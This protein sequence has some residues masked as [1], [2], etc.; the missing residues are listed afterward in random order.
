MTGSKNTHI[1]TLVE[2]YSRFTKL[3][4]VSDKNTASVVAALIRRV[5]R[6]PSAL[7]RLLTGGDGDGLVISN[8]PSL[9]T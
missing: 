2:R 8:V 4:K 9:P 1:A 6:L 3:V 7:G 5:R